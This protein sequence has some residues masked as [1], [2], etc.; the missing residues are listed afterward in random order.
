[1]PA[2]SVKQRRFLSMCEHGKIGKSQ[3]PH[4]TKSQYKDFTKTKEKNLPMVAGGVKKYP[5]RRR[6]T[7]N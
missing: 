3:C 1:M 2:K 6:K 4:M 5:P 7:T